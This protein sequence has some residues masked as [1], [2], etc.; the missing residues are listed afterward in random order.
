MHDGPMPALR[1]EKEDRSRQR[2]QTRVLFASD[3]PLLSAS[4]T[5]RSLRRRFSVLLPDAGAR[6][7]V[8]EVVI[9]FMTCVFVHLLFGVDLGPGNDRRP[10]PGPRGRVLD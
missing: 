2:Q 9:V 10:R 1:R 6:Q 5:N 7:E 4:A 3:S 8:D